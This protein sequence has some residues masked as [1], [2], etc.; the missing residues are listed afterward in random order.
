MGFSDITSS[1]ER[2][3]NLSETNRTGASNRST[4]ATSVA[5]TSTQTQAQSPSTGTTDKVSISSEVQAGESAAASSAVNFGAW[6][7]P[8]ATSAAPAKEVA[9]AGAVDLGSATLKKG[10]SGENVESLQRMLNEKMGTNL[11]VDGKFGQKTL[12]AVKAYQKSQGLEAD[13]IVGKDTKGAFS[14][15]AGTADASAPA[16]KAGEQPVG[17]EQAKATAEEAAQKAAAEQTSG[18]QPADA[19]KA[20][21]GATGE[22]KVPG[23]DDTSWTEKLPK[24][25]QQHADAFVEAGKKY[26]VDPRLLA[27]ISMQETGGGRSKAINNKNNAMGIMGSSGL[28]RFQSVQASIESQARSLSREGGYYQGADTIGEIA[29]I[30]APVGAKNDPNGLNRH[31]RNNVTNFF[32]D[33]GGN[34]SDQVKGFNS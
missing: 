32:E 7:T 19:A 15:A 29:G 12:D 9:A 31:W 28:K 13:G 21:D 30:Y 8:A 26:G 34:R 18:E 3:R 5:Q 33:L 20:Q 23:T 27:A 11:E 17:A 22:S 6:D 16:A 4:E 25:L 14:G 1:T 24:G 2:S 10:A